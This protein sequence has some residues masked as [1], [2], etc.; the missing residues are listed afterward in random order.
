[1]NDLEKSII[2]TLAFFD[3]FNYP[4]T[5]S[6]IWKWLYMPDKKYSLR[7]VKHALEE[8]DFLKSE[9]SSQEG[10]YSLEGRD[11]I[12]LRRKQ[13]NN[14][15]ER[16]FRRARNIA[17]IYRFIPY[18]RM[19]AVCNSLAYSNAGEE[20]DIDL[21]IITKRKTIWLARFFTVLLIFTFGMRPKVENKKDSFCLSFFVDEDHL[22]IHATM[23]NSED[24]YYPYWVSQL[25][26]IYNPDGLYEK[27]LEANS[28]YK[29]YLPNAYANQFYKSVKER[30]YSKLVSGFFYGLF[31][32]PY[33]KKAIYAF[34]RKFQLQIIDRNLKSLINV[35]TRIVINEGM[36]KFYP[37]DNRELFYKK[38]KYRVHNL[39]KNNEKDK[40]QTI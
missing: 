20:S 35:D 18:V 13:N 8:S 19:I 36:L 25:M 7:D 23:M 11:N 17:R 6:E 10:F 30:S 14:L 32:I 15:A 37:N 5:L 28:W 40:S 24:I 29:E 22:N 38:W 2:K 31:N 12:Y 16:K 21:F 27:F 39:L 33:F 4:L 9:I 1:M 34:F 26:P 3:V